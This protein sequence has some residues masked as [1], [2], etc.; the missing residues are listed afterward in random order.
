MIIDEQFYITPEVGLRLFKTL[1][2]RYPL[3][4]LNARIHFKFFFLWRTWH[5][6]PEHWFCRVQ[7]S[8]SWISDP[9]DTKRFDILTLRGEKENVANRMLKQITLESLELE[10]GTCIR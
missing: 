5:R 7:F 3:W 6:G 2:P 8:S 4:C 10:A 1:G 9:K